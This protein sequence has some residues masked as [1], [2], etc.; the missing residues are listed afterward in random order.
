M[1]PDLLRF[2]RTLRRF[3]IF[4]SVCAAGLFLV[5]TIL[6]ITPGPDPRSIPALY[7]V[8]A[9]GIAWAARSCWRLSSAITLAAAGSPQPRSRPSRSRL[10]RVHTAAFGY[11]AVLFVASAAAYGTGAAALIWVTSFGASAV[12]AVAMRFRQKKLPPASH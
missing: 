12:I 4:E 1:T 2:A 5:G 3:A 9:V 7:V 8:I 11:F 10:I 6:L